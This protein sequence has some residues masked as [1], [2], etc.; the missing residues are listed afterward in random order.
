ME[1]L[2]HFS[3]MSL[4]NEQPVP[5][6][7]NT[8]QVGRERGDVLWWRLPLLAWGHT[9]SGCVF[10]TPEVQAFDLGGN[11]VKGM[12]ETTMMYSEKQVSQN[13]AS[14]FRRT[15]LMVHSLGWWAWGR[16]LSKMLSSRQN[17]QL[18]KNGDF[19]PFNLIPYVTSES[20]RPH[21]W[22][23]SPMRGGKKSQCVLCDPNRDSRFSCGGRYHCTWCRNL[24]SCRGRGD[25]GWESPPWNVNGKT[26]VLPV[27]NIAPDHGSLVGSQGALVSWIL[28]G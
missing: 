21:P 23:A 5:L 18:L 9:A 20:L 19:Y 15:E 1:L 4:A 16:E 10:Q 13:L 11:Q 2:K 14:S 7:S 3:L 24:Y 8:G 25:G 17:T 28:R 22:M 12:M 6:K 26:S 27:A